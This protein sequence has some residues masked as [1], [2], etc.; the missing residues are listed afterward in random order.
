MNAPLSMASVFFAAS[1]VLG[2]GVRPEPQMQAT[3]LSVQKIHE[4]VYMVKGGAGANAG[5]I[6]GE[7]EVFVIDVKMTAES[8]AEMLA[9]I[10]RVTRFPV[11]AILLTHSDRDHVDGFPGFSK[12]LRIIAQQNCLK[13][14]EDASAAQPFLKDY[15]PTMTFDKELAIKSGPLSVELRHHGPAHTSGDTVVNVPGASV[16][17]V[18]DLVFLGRDP[19][20]HRRKNGSSAGLLTTLKAILAYEPSIETFIPGHGEPLGRND[21]EGLIKSVEEKRE[22]VAGLV[23][24]GKTLDEVKKAFGIAEPPAGQMR[25]P[26]LVEII[27]LELTEKR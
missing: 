6:I 4:N 1:A 8:S 20:I 23:A 15:L 9:A 5:F 7:K 2:A 27:Y 3:P 24:A 16:A 17:F 14:L 10:G 19:L 11:T 21:I 13:E 12:G 18:G 26:S 25:F 22:K